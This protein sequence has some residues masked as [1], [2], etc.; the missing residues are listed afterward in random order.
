[1]FQ[2]LGAVLVKLGR[3]DE[4]IQVLKEGFAV[5]D[6]RGDNMPRDEIAQLLGQLGEPVP[7]SK[8]APAAAADAGAG[9]FRCSRPGCPYGSRARKLPAPPMKDEVGQ[10][11]GESICADCWNDW[12]RNY[13]VKVINELR[14][15]L[16]REDHQAA[17]DEQMR[18]F[19]GFE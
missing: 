15:D 11:I 9:G 4:A 5:A 17:Y 12:F 14:L 10:R 16:S 13:S 3:R 19:F 2:L 7:A 6:E 18:G 1:V 8:R